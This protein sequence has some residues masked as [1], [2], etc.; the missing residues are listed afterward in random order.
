VQIVLMKTKGDRFN[1]KE[2]IVV[3]IAFR[4]FEVRSGHFC[5][6]VAT[7]L[8]TELLQLK[9]PVKKHLPWVVSQSRHC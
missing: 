2:Q 5:A 7:E 4:R 6:F 8:V 1:L 9:S 3:G